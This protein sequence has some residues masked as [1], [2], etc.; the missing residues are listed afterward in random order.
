MVQCSLK[1]MA[2]NS[3]NE[4]EVDVIYREMI[5]SFIDRANELA[6]KNSSENVGMAYCLRLPGLTPS[7][8][9]STLKTGRIMREIWKKRRNFSS[10]NISKCSA[11][12]SKTI[13]RYLKN[14]TSLLGLNS[15]R[16]N[17]F[18][19]LLDHFLVLDHNRIAK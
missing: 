15:I 13:K 16:F 4:D 1:L 10:P 3:I 18:Q 14:T 9:R 11:K 5:D 8:Y 6:D 12:I 17:F 2:E 7:S 19:L